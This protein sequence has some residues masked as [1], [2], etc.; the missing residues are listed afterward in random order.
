VKMFAKLSLLIFLLS[1]LKLSAFLQRTRITFKNEVSTHSLYMGALNSSPME[2][3]QENA[4]LV[5]DEVR[6]ELGTIFG[7]DEGSRSAGITGKI[8]L[9]EVDGPSIVIKLRYL[10]YPRAVYSEISHNFN[11]ILQHKLIFSLTLL[12]RSRRTTF[13]AVDS[14]TRRI[15]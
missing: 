3:C 6:K 8:D 5:I 11:I 7:Y 4:E 15:L 10:T 14:G 12:L 9:V 1:A 13:S 2:L